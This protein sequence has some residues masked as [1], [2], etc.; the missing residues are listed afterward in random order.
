MGIWLA[1][2]FDL[3]EGTANP[4]VSKFELFF[5]TVMKKHIERLVS[6]YPEKCSLMIDFKEIEKFDFELADEL[7]SNPDLVLAAAK[8]AVKKIEVPAIGI[9]DF[10]P[11]VRVFNLPKESMPL[12]RDIGSTQLNKLIAVEGVV[13]QFTEVKPKLKIA[14][15][16]CRKCGNAYRVEQS[17]LKLVQPNSCSNCRVRDFK[18]ASEKSQFID[19]QKIS[20]QEPLEQLKGGEQASNLDIFVSDDLVNKVS[21]G[22][23]TIIVGIL[24]LHD[25]KFQ[26]TVYGRHLEAIH[27]E[28][29]ELEFEE[30]EIS[31]EE[32]EQIREL[33]SKKEVY[34]LLIN[35]IAPAIYGHDIVKEA[36][37]LQ[38]FSGVKKVLPDDT[39]IRGNIHVLLVGEPGVAKSQLLQAADKIA[40]KSIYTSGKTSS[41]VGLCVAPN[42]LV[43]NDN[44]FRSIKEFVEEKFVSEKAIEEIPDAFANNW[45][46]KSFS[47]NEK[48]EIEESGVYKI[49]KIKSPEKMIKICTVLGKEISITPQTSLI[50]FRNNKHNWVR[51]GDLM[52]GDFVACARKLP[53]GKKN[54]IPTILCLE[55]DKNIKI[56]SNVSLLLKEITNKLVEKH[57]SLQ[58]IGKKIEKSRDTIYA[59]R[60]PKFYHGISLKNFLSLGR[61]AGFSDEY[62]ARQV[63]EVFI[64][65][66]KNIKIP[67]YLDNEELAYLAGLALGDGNVYRSKKDNSVAVRIFSA[68]PEILQKVDEIVEKNFGIKTQKFDDKIRVPGRRVS[69]RVFFNVLQAFGLV[70][71]K[72]E[73]TISHL[74]T[75][76]NNKII[77]SLLSGLFDTDGYVSAPKK[78]RG[79][80]HIGISTISK[81]MAQKAQLCL[82]KFEILSKIRLRKKIGKKAVGKKISVTSR[83]DQYCIEIHGKKNLEKFQQFIG[84][85]LERKKKK[86]EQAISSISKIG[87]SNIE[88]IPGN[89]S[90]IWE[91]I[92]ELIEE[93]PEF[94]FVYDF[95]VEKN[96]NFIGNGFIVHNTASAVKDEFG[97]GGWTLKAG[98]LVLASGGIAFVDE[99]DKMESTD[100]DAMHEAMEQGMVS[101]A[102]AGIVTRFKTETSILAAA[103]PKF[104]RF[105]QFVSLMEQIDLPP[106]LISRFD[107]FFLVKDV[108]D[109]KKDTEIASHILQIH[110]AGEILLQKD[111]NKKLFEKQLIESEKKFV[112]PISRELLRKYISYAR[113]NVFPVLSEEAIN[114]ISEYYVNLREKGKK[115][116]NYTATHRQLEALIRLSEASARIRLV[117]NVEKIDAE[118][119]IRLFNKSLE[120]VVTDPTTGKIDI[121][122]ITSGTPH[123]KMNEMK[124]VLAITKRIAMEKDLVPLDE[125]IEESYAEGIDKQKA[126]DFIRELHKIGEIYEVRQGLFKIAEKK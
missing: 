37:A 83:F 2:D 126:H 65:H 89:D 102:K 39:R 76:M 7:L 75:E 110:Q 78:H 32:V 112:P 19:Y 67:C 116:G 5:K 26:G 79:S 99:F 44:G 117:D 36:I 25:P 61:E 28:E 105:D 59:I 107:L 17:T 46:G 122:I 4:F 47:A 125:I 91:E 115:E 82:L 90:I 87:R 101:I 84:F 1:T 88:K 20:I 94:D 3:M 51:A 92:K 120:E 104:S 58:E 123:S 6:H 8:E 34:D 72:S 35:S 111:E 85:R 49:W 70:E 52:K 56:K 21:P 16:E 74:A 14:V 63:E 71:K 23:R 80:S 22:D 57:G 64:S 41:G 10:A 9:D 29:T 54:N 27:V 114:T 40:P 73:I 96:H 95:S 62:L 113:Q 33:A 38:L 77:G 108:L 106:T 18:L 103:N 121:D 31:E 48:L 69:S 118:R 43:L 53:E 119:A 93:K 30:L 12:I 100:R 60:N 11:H 50:A 55:K 81:N 66:G 68:S 109:R 86:L 24:R 45:Q 98:A 15:W 42:T 124:K 13:R 97:E